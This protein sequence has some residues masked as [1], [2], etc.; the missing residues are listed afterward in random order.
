MDS[1]SISIALDAFAGALALAI[2]VFQLAVSRRG[3][4]GRALCIMCLLLAAY[5]VADAWS[6]VHM[7]QGGTEGWVAALPS[8]V[9]GCF[10]A[11]HIVFMWK[12][13]DV[14]GI[15]IVPSIFPALA[16]VSAVVLP[17][18]ALPGIICACG[19]LLTLTATIPLRELAVVRTAA[20]LDRARADTVLSQIQPHFL[21]NTL[22]AIRY[23][24]R[25]DPVR[26]SEM[27][28]DFSEYLR[29]NMA[30]LTHA[31]PIPFIEE[32]RHAQKCLELEQLRLGERLRVNY[33]IRAL[34]FE[35]PALTLQTLAENAVRHGIAKRPEGGSLRISSYLVGNLACVEVE[36]D[37]VGFD[38]GAPLGA[39][40]EHVGLE[41][42]RLRL[43]TMCE[44]RLRIESRPGLGTCATVEIP[45]SEAMVGGRQ[46]TTREA[47][48]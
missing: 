3:G 40:R 45:R 43:A 9:A 7:A 4:V 29:G 10:M 30:S 46:R 44:G 42:A 13:Y 27:L 41:S 18:L 47:R 33:D 28:D 6:R 36:D 31:E 19:V 35:L 11:G 23:L 37:G 1:V 34:G 14:Y 39:D 5:C 2:A 24:C 21:Y 22:T 38:V 15:G 25:A 16:I 17:S 48:R 12:G 20:E 8:I 32:L 26:A